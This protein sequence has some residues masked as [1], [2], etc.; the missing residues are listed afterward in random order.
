MDGKKWD[1]GSGELLKNLD[2]FKHHFLRVFEKIEPGKGG[3]FQNTILFCGFLKNGTRAFFKNL[4]FP[5][6]HLPAIQQMLI[7]T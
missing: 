1:F 7:L 3:H 4:K 2:F 6:Y 5:K